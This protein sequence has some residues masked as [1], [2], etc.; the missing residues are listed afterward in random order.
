MVHKQKK[1]MTLGKQIWLIIIVLIM[2]DFCFIKDIKSN[3]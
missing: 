3:A 2:L 1:Y